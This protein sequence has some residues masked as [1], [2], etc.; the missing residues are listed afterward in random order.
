MLGVAF[1]L[2]AALG[3]GGSAVLARLGMRSMKATTGT[4]VSL[5]VSTVATMA[6]A[7]SLHTGEILKL[8]GMAFVWFLVAGLLSYPVGR[9]LNYTGVRLAGVS[10]GSSIVGSAP[11]FATALAVLVGGESLSA[12]ILVGTLAIIGGLALILS[13]Q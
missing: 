7:V 8:Q 4:L 11:L 2:S 3:F 5:V 9:L 6:I 1:S 10:K 13:Q 12:P